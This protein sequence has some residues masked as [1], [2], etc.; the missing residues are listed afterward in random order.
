MGGRLNIQP[1]T[2]YLLMNIFTT[3]EMFILNMR[4]IDQIFYD[5]IIDEMV[6]KII[7]PEGSH[8]LNYDLPY[9]VKQLPAFS[10]LYLFRYWR[11]SCYICDYE[12]FGGK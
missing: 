8:K 12:K 11:K 5:M 3:L 4:L 2:M 7:L 1:G 9:E 10:V 6:I